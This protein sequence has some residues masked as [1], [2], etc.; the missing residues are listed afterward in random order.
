MKRAAV[1]AQP[2]GHGGEHLAADVRG[3]LL[4]LCP[5]PVSIPDRIRSV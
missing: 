2:Y 1:T 3:V 4:G 5:I